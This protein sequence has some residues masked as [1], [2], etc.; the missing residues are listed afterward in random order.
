MK[1]S[2]L[3]AYVTVATSASLVLTACS[4]GNSSSGK[5]TIEFMTTSTEKER[6]DNI[7]SMI[8]QF[9]A[10]NKGIDIKLVPVEEDALNTK[11]VTL[12]RAKKLPAVVEVS[13]DYAKVMDQQELTDNKL[14]TEVIKSVGEDNYYNGA[15]KLVRSEDGKDFIAAPISG[16]VQGIWY[17]KTM[18]KD[19]GFE[20][21]ESWEDI[22]KIAEH[23][24]DVK[25]KKYGIALPTVDGTFSEQ[26]F[27]QFALSNG[28]NVLDKDGKVTIDTKEMQ[29]ALSFYK[30]LYQYALPG[31]NDTTEVNDAFMNGTAPMAIYSTYILPGAF[32]ADKASD[33]GF[34][35][36]KKNDSAVYG[37]VSALT[38]ANGLDENQKKAAKKFVE[39]M[40]KP[41]QVESWTLM[42]PM[43]AQPVNKNVVESSTYRENKTVKA[44]GDLSTQIAGA[45]DKI[46]VFG[47]IGDK[48]F[49]SM[50]SI[51][52]SGA[53]GKAVYNVTVK[54]GDVEEAL[55]EAQKAA[56]SAE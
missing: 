21:P 10:D 24:T 1:F 18:L 9:E 50:G 16:W 46:Q 40:S 43:G 30:E 45:F 25:N 53:V 19:A 7:N 26:A 52:S 41:E 23:F 49:K 14:T 2:K 6:Q 56:E 37:T 54:N 29:E 36:P 55:K 11:V 15:L 27:S 38:I 28:A 13:Q 3:M 34:A 32:E 5:T 44:Y 4:S 8:K 42:S 51:T 20:A 39:Y 17:N 31:S 47:L 33:I 12:A 48:N 35:V 22:I